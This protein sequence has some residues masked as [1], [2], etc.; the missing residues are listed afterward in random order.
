MHDP[1][2]VRIYGQP[3][4][5]Q[6]GARKCTRCKGINNYNADTTGCPDQF[7]EADVYKFD[8]DCYGC[9]M[10]SSKKI[11]MNLIT[12]YNEWAKNGK[13]LYIYS[14][15]PGSGKT[16]LACCIGKSIMMKYGV[17]F[18]FITAPGYINKVSEG[19]TLAKQG[20]PDSPARIY[21]E[22][23]VLVLDDIGTQ[24]AKEWQ[25]QE[26][27]ML[28]N[29]RVNKGLITIYTSNLDIQNLNVSE[30]IKSRIYGTSLLFGMP[31]VSVRKN[32]AR[33]ANN[34]FLKKMMGE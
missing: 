7:R 16:Y 31:E 14:K 32:K 3:F 17:R 21:S 22:C 23:E 1:D 9:D 28:I 10:S 15:T 4:E 12:R 2:V 30:R 24:L 26:L 18:K 20:I 11:V 25:E 33:E 27:F 5:V 19:I 13:G 34:D 29:E 8:F 6:E